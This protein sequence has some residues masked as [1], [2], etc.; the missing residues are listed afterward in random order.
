MALFRGQIIWALPWVGS[1]GR[2]LHSARYELSCFAAACWLCIGKPYS[3]RV[4]PHTQHIWGGTFWEK[5]LELCWEQSG[6]V[7]NPSDSAHLRAVLQSWCNIVLELGG[8]LEAIGVCP[9]NVV[10]F[11]NPKKTL[12]TKWDLV[13]C[14]S[15]FSPH[16]SICN[17]FISQHTLQ[18][19]YFF[20]GS[21]LFIGK[22]IKHFVSC[23]C[24]TYGKIISLHLLVEYLSNF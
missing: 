11:Y 1:S 21:K 15:R 7:M 18:A 14:C 5:G 3:P 17:Y 24:D 10:R 8:A 9:K 19:V 6:V 12:H 16:S 4:P 20:P 13:S 22:S 23:H 2:D